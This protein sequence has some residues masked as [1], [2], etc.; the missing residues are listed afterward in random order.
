[1]TLAEVKYHHYVFV[2]QLK[3]CVGLQKLVRRTPSSPFLTAKPLIDRDAHLNCT[4]RRTGQ[5]SLQLLSGL[6]GTSSRCVKL[7]FWFG[8][9]SA[10]F[11]EGI[12]IPTTVCTAP[13][14]VWRS[15]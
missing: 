8:F 1:A 10:A 11:A 5:A 13:R 12:S 14:R 7:D 4:L 3:D 15:R 2:F 6:P 9:P